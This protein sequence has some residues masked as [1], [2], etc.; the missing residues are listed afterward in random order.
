MMANLFVVAALLSILE[1][2]FLHLV[3]PRKIELTVVDAL[4]TATVYSNYFFLPFTTKIRKY[5]D[6][7]QAY[8]NSR[9]QRD[10]HSTYKVY[11]L[12]LEYSERSVILFQGKR[13]D[14]DLL[15]YC[16]KIN[17]FITS[18]ED[19]VVYESKI[20]KLKIALVFVLFLLCDYD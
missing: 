2:I 20:M 1:L 18:F 17:L 19:C 3:S 11:D 13:T 6:I 4:P 15:K 5:K 9:I 7:K 8:I 14:E 12:V 16:D 10:K